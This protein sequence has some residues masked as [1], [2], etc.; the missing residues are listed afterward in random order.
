MRARDEQNRFA[1]ARITV[2]AAP[3][4]NH[5][6]TSKPHGQ[7]ASPTSNQPRNASLHPT[8]RVAGTVS[9]ARNPLAHFQVTY[10]Q[11]L[12]IRTERDGCRAHS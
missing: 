10:G 11:Y 7:F 5:A 12:R 8:P 6:F 9:S 1:R 2:A 3:D 4:P